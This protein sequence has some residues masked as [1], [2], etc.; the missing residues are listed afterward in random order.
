MGTLGKMFKI[1]YISFFHSEPRGAEMLGSFSSIAARDQIT[2]E[3]T[4]CIFL[5]DYYK[6]HWQIHEDFSFSN[7]TDGRSFA[8]TLENWEVIV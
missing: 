8:N 4:F 6:D 2:A 1:Y 7:H 3:H 5:W